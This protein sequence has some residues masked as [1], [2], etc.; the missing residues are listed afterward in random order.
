MNQHPHPRPARHQHPGGPRRGPGRPRRRSPNS[1]LQQ[2]RPALIA[3]VLLLVVATVGFAGGG[4]SA[5][6]TTTT[7]TSLPPTPQTTP[8]PPLTRTLTQGAIGEDVRMVQQRLKDLAFDPNLVDGDYGYNTMQAVWAFEKLV[9]QRPR[10][11]ATGEVTPDMWEMMKRNDLIT[12]R[13]PNAQTP[14]HVEIYL[15]EQV[16]VV[17]AGGK[18]SLVTHISSGDN[19][20]WC[21]EV[22]I[23]PGEQGNPGDEPIKK[24]ICGESITPAGL[25]YFYNRRTGTRQSKLGTMWNPVYFNEGI[26]VHGAAQVPLQPA[27]HG[28]VRIPMHVSEY[29]PSLVEYG[30]RVYV[31]D[32]VK[33]PEEYGSPVPPADRPDPNYTTTTSVTSSTS[34]TSVPTT[35]T[36]TTVAP[37]TTT[38]VKPKKNQTTTVPATEPT[39]NTTAAPSVDVTT[40][41]AS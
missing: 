11:N 3:L 29:F 9:M 27:S 26:A 25:Y 39:P 23:D 24:G 40:S 2:W 30:D 13:R 10:A 17:F 12:P 14:R 8:L 19:K 18:P 36:S 7:T 37:T 16:M 28:C 22:T 20:P 15:P 1:P 41:V 31:F 32:G 34:T 4:D 5:P 38:T 33:E 35:T 21:E 6:G